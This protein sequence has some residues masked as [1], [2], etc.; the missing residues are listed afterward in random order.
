[1][2]PSV[3]VPEGVYDRG[4]CGGYDGDSGRGS[5]GIFGGGSVR[6]SV[7]KPGLTCV[8]CPLSGGYVIHGCLHCKQTLQA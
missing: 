2:G 4:F 7:R 5:A 8:A 6:G 1:M 3:G